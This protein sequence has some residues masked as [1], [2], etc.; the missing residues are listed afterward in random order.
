MTPTELKQNIWQRLETMEAEKL[1][2]VMDFLDSLDASLSFQNQQKNSKSHYETRQAFTKSLR[3]MASKSS[4]SSDKFAEKKQE[5]ID[6]EER[7]R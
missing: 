5:E 4:F 6:W 7:H 3:G 1:T 2:A